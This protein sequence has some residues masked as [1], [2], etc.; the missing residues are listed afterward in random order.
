VILRIALF[1]YLFM[2]MEIFIHRY[3]SVA[4]RLLFKIF[5]SISVAV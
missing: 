5:R 2:F 1:I 4:S 3:L